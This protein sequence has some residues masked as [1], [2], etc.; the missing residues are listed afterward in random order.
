M[1]AKPSDLSSLV[2]AL[3]QLHEAVLLWHAEVQT[4]V[5]K[6][7][8]CSAI[9]HS[10]EVTYGLSV[11]LIKSTLLERSRGAIVDLSFDDL[12]RKAADAG[13]VAAPDMWREWHEL[14]DSI[15]HTHDESK[16]TEVAAGVERFANAAVEL[17]GVL[18][19]EMPE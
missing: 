5:L 11:R 16:A 2:K 17:A 19:R 13:L 14:R 18:E 15:S 12:L 9:I 1:I 4:S 6:R 8:L 7:H 10:S 3:A